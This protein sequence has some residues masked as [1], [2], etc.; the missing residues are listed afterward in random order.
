MG[1]DRG[2]TAVEQGCFGKSG[3]KV[4]HKQDW[5]LL[6]DRLCTGF[7]MSEAEWGSVKYSPSL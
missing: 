6:L 4:C 2:K 5:D 7:D 3:G 1:A